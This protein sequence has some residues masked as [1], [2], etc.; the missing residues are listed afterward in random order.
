MAHLAQAGMRS[1]HSPYAVSTLAFTLL[2]HEQMLQCEIQAAVTCFA[3]S[4]ALLLICRWCSLPRGKAL[5][6]QHVVRLRNPKY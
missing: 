6:G 2:L 3:P 1:T 5:H 4:S